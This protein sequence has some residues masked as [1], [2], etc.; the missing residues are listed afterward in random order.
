FSHQ[1]SAFNSS[2]Q[3]WQ[4]RQ[5]LAIEQSIVNR[6]SSNRQLY[7]L[8]VSN[9][10]YFINSLKNPDSKRT[11]ARHA[12]TLSPCDLFDG[13]N[14]LLAMDGTFSIIIP[15]D[16]VND[17]LTE[18]YLHHLYPFSKCYVK[19]LP[20]K[21]PKRCLLSFQKQRPTNIDETVVNMMESPT[22]RSEW[23]KK[24]TEDYYL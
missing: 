17:Y 20:N 8:V 15:S 23:Y 24:L 14:R 3:D 5:F 6:Q 16:R 19:T 13:V 10:P 9:P 22:E 11:M 2:L 18:G 21:Q 4:N 12:D 1:L 7:D